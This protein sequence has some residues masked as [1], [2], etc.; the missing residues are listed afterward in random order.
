MCGIWQ[1]TA[2]LP[3]ARLP[4]LAHRGVAW[5]ILPCC[6]L[7]PPPPRP[8]LWGL[9]FAAASTTAFPPFLSEPVLPPPIPTNQLPDLCCPSSSSHWLGGTWQWVAPPEVSVYCIH[10]KKCTVIWMKVFFYCQNLVAYSWLAH[11]TFTMAHVWET[12]A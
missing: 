7:P 6:C 12:L 3:V 4:P 2:H 5:V 1:F 8:F 9:C 11:D 10:R